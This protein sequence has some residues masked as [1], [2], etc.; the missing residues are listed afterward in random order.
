MSHSTGNIRALFVVALSLVA[1]WFSPIASANDWSAY[2]DSNSVRTS[3]EQ[4]GQTTE[5]VLGG[6]FTIL[7]YPTNTSDNHFNDSPKDKEGSTIV[8]VN[9]QNVKFSVKRNKSGWLVL[10]PTTKEGNNYVVGAF[11]KSST[12]KFISMDNGFTFVVSAK[13]VQKAWNH[14]QRNKAI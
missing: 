1:L 8:N 12:V 4:S 13:G 14:L 9:G 11:W 2:L 10:K 7:E 6:G 3:F 5:L